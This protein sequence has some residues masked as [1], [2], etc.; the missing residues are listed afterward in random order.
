MQDATGITPQA[1]VDRPK[2]FGI[3]SEVVD[4]YNVLAARRTS[5]GFAMNPLQLSEIMA[6]LQIV[7]RPSIPI[8]MFIELLGIMD[9]R[10]LELTNGNRTSKRTDKSGSKRI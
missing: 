10:Y 9:I 1:L 3:A 2:I 6:Y 4:A 8:T 7:G 5:S